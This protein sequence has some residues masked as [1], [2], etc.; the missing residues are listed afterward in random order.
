MFRGKSN[1]LVLTFNWLDILDEWAWF[2]DILTPDEAIIQESRF[3]SQHTFTW[4]LIINPAQTIPSTIARVPVPICPKVA[5][6]RGQVILS[7]HQS[8]VG[9]QRA[10][11]MS[12]SFH[13]NPR[14]FSSRSHTS[15]GTLRNHPHN[16]TL[17][18]AVTAMITDPNDG[19]DQGDASN[20]N[21]AYNSSAFPA[22]NTSAALARPLSH[23]ENQLPTLSQPNLQKLAQSGTWYL[24]KV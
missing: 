7:M 24:F 17:Q 21:T 14:V 1:S 4:S 15:K 11:T 9:F 8:P 3:R 22:G 16:P 5:R 10:N 6:A 12:A 18:R 2:G 19:R 20:N 13:A 23:C